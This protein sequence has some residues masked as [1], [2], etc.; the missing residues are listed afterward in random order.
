[1]P[2][3][4]NDAAQSGQTNTTAA[5]T[6]NTG[7]GT[8]TAFSAVNGTATF[9]NTHPW[10]S[11]QD[12]KLA[13]G[14]GVRVS[15]Q[16]SAASTS[17]TN[18]IRFYDYLVGTVAPTAT[19]I[20]IQL[21]GSGVNFVGVNTTAHPIVNINSAN[22]YTSTYT[23]LPNTFY[24]PEVWWEASTS[25]DFH[26]RLFVENSTTEVDGYDT[27]I[28]N[29]GATN[30]GTF[31]VGKQSTSGNWCE[32]YISM[33]QVSTGATDFIGPA[34]TSI[35]RPNA[36]IT[37][38]NWT[39]STGT[40]AWPLLSDGSDT[41]YVTSQAN[42]AGQPLSVQLSPTNPIPNQ[43]TV[44]TDYTPD[45]SSGSIGAKL[46]MGATLMKTWSS[47]PVTGAAA[48][49]TFSLTPAERA[50]VTDGTNLRFETDATAS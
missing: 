39:P 30:P 27:T 50:T 4:T 3:Y 19:Q 38:T 34:A 32:H 49:Y 48:T 40:L 29:T 16:M 9:D 20:W 1:M 2:N 46:Y 14:T 45:A 44:R 24:R 25:G 31:I 23:L 36:D 42:P 21:Q 13:A 43:F 6:G 11:T 10:A 18:A 8:N 26:Y 22:V 15:L 17:A 47:V 12:Y 33:L 5:T 37:T 28:A 35:G 7:G 41:T